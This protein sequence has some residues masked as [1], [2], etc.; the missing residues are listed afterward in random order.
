MTVADVELVVIGGSAGSFAGLR[1]ILPGLALPLALPVVVVIHLP[2][3][4]PSAIAEIF[5]GETGLPAKEAEDKEPLDCK[6]YFAAP[7]YH[8]LI[9]ADRTL[10]LA[11]DEPVHFSRPSID[12]LFQSAADAF[13]TGVLG[14]ILS[15]A[16]EDGAAGL[17]AIVARGG[18]ALV[19]DPDAAEYPM[20]PRA[21]LDAAPGA[22]ALTLDEIRRALLRLRPRRRASAETRH[23]G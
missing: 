23:D 10:A 13:G 22:T 11:V 8:L 21:A 4:R 12:V 9:E 14:I 18:R 1:T 2:P 5:L 16:N 17:A 3:D 6:V 7:G 20:M 19:E 15:G